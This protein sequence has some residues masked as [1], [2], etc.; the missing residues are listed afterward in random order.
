[1]QASSRYLP[2][3][4]CVRGV[5][6]LLALWLHCPGT[7]SAQDPPPPRETQVAPPD[8][9]PAPVPDMPAPAPVD[10]TPARQVPA[11]DQ[12]AGGALRASPQGGTGE[13][14]SP[15]PPST[16]GS[17]FD[18]GSY[19]RVGI[20][21]DLRGHTGTAVNVVSFGSRLEEPAYLEL[22]FYYGGIIGDD[23]T[24]RWRVVVVPAFAGDLFH[25][26]GNFSQQFAL[27][28]AYAETE[29]LG[30]HG[31]SLWAGSRTYRGD[32]VYLFDFWPLD[33]LNTVGGGANYRFDRERT[34]LA[35]HLGM[36]RLDSLF[37]HQVIQVPSRNLPQDG[38]ILDPQQATTS[39]TTLDRPRVVAS[40]KG[41]HY[42]RPRGEAPN[43]KVVLYGEFHYLPAGERQDPANQTPALQLKEDFGWVVGAQLGAWLRPFVFANLFLRAA[44]G[45]AAFGDLGKPHGFDSNL[46]ALEA[47][48]VTLAMSAN[49]E[50]N[51][52]GLMAGGYFRYFRDA[53][54]SDNTGFNEGAL[55]L[56]PQIYWTQYFHTAVELS[57]QARHYATSDQDLGVYLTPQVFRASL[58]PIVAPL[59]RGTYS[60]PAIFAIYTVSFLNDD[61][62]YVL[63]DPRDVRA[64]TNV[65]HYLGLGAEWWFNSSYR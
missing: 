46:Q 36:N 54:P 11:K 9:I 32:D 44:G 20:G 47:R 38:L 42:F 49:W 35:I 12:R 3:R 43:G 24:R 30:L 34:D 41:T 22:N 53:N 51:A 40:F 5:P 50:S 31:L 10:G 58:I 2:T 23:P 8:D 64:G 39:V 7:A 21:T 27:R 28:N 61:A 56:R 45:L 29:N 63:F 52:L 1:M 65:V 17:G 62:R 59:G 33:N 60:R 14:G 57:Y 26:T 15:P 37:Q 16:T 13:S 25:Y 4:A 55:A 18:F 19:G 48:E 6:A